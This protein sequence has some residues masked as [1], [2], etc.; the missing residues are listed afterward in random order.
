MVEL[1][2]VSMQTARKGLIEG[3]RRGPSLRASTPRTRNT[4]AR[5]FS[6]T[7]P[8]LA[9]L[10]RSPTTFASA[11]SSAGAVAVEIA[12]TATTT[13]EISESDGE[14]AMRDDAAERAMTMA[15]EMVWRA[16][17]L[18][19]GRRELSRTKA[20]TFICGCE[21]SVRERHD[22]LD[23]ANDEP[24]GPLPGAEGREPRR[25]TR[26]TASEPQHRPKRWRFRKC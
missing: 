6:E 5:D 9:S 18:T 21:R 1:D 13:A 20:L 12:C 7:E 23:D 2:S 14:A 16:S 10:M 26:P 8:F 24:C 19:T 15:G 25:K 11:A 4:F 22:E 3:M 17:G